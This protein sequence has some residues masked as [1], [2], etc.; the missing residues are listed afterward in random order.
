VEFVLE[1]GNAISGLQRARTR[2]RRIRHGFASYASDDRDEVLG[3]VQGMLKIAPTLDIFLD[4][5]SPRSGEQW[6]ARLQEEISR[7]DIFYLFWS[8]AASRSR[9]VDHEWRWAL[10]ERGLEFI[11]PVP[12]Q[13]P[14]VVPPPA[15]LA[16]LH[17]NDWT[18]AFKRSRELS[19]SSQGQVDT[20]GQP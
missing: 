13:S 6:S 4:V 15:E 16:T 9:H 14:D 7:C 12:L 10:H 11:D 20:A 3:R 1:V 19:V 2:E 5:L 8:T 17:F 18:L